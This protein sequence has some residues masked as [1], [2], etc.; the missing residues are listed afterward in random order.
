M[1]GCGG[2]ELVREW[3][4]DQGYG[5][6]DCGQPQFEK[7]R[8]AITASLSESPVRTRTVPH[9]T[10][11][12]WRELAEA[13]VPYGQ[14]QR[15]KRCLKKLLLTTDADNLGALVAIWNLLEHLGK[16]QA[17]EMVFHACLTLNGAAGDPW[18]CKKSEIRRGCR[19]SRL[20]IS[21][22]QRSR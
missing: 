5:K 1:A 4:R 16:D 13:F 20:E 22:E 14:R 17:D 6:F 15:E 3:A 9:W 12:D 10:Q 2:E 7:W 18:S 8:K 11:D 19:Q 21:M